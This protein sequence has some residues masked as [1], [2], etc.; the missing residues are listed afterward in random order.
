MRDDQESTERTELTTAVGQVRDSVHELA[1]VAPQE[2]ERAANRAN[3]KWFP[4][5]VFSAAAAAAIVAAAISVASLNLG[6]RNQQAISEQAAY[7]ATTRQLAEDA[8]TRGDEANAEL[9]RRGQA[10]V[11]I[12]DVGQ[13]DDLEVTRASIVAEVLTEVLPEVD[14]RPT[15]AQ[16]AGAVAVYMRDN[17]APGPTALQVFEG[18]S[19]Y[20]T[21]NPQPAGPQGEQGEP[22]QQGEA[23]QPGVQGPQGEQGPPPTV[24]EMQAAFTAFIDANPDYLPAVLCRDRGA[25]SLVELRA[26]DG[27][28]VTGY[29]CVTGTTSPG[30]PILGG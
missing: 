20:L 3:R 13:A 25:W 8:K 24:E 21:A 2:A 30:L 27:G 29:L 6:L 26:A 9:A 10:Q 7:Q 18:I 11:P 15:A 12:P 22:G 1:G 14:A 4:R 16:I 23:G 17:P 28:T 5:T 19:A